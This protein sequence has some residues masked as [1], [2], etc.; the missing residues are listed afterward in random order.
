M[1]HKLGF[2]WANDLDVTLPGVT[3]TNQILQRFHTKL[4][5]HKIYIPKLEILMIN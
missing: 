3:K 2:I 5:N 1:L 4:S